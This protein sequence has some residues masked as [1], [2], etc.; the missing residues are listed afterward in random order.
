MVILLMIVGAL[1]GL[2]THEGIGALLGATIGWLVASAIRQGRRIAQ[3]EQ[4]LGERAER[5]V[6]PP[7]DRQTQ[8]GPTP[9][10]DQAREPATAAAAAAPALASPVSSLATA[11]PPSPPLPSAAPSPIVAPIPIPAR[12][13]AAAESDTLAPGERATRPASH[14]AAGPTTPP[15][16]AGEAAGERRSLLGANTII[17]VG[18][19]ILFVGLAFL[20]KYLAGRVTIPVELRL[21][22]IAL[23]AIVLTLIG[24]W[25][26][27]RRPRYAQVLQGGGIAVLYL[28]LF[29]SFRWYGVLAMAPAFVLMAI[30]AMLAAALAVLQEA[31]A[32]AVVGALGG[33]ATPLLVSTGVGNH[34][35]LFTYYLVLDLA[36]AAIAWFRN[37]RPLNLIG[38]AF[39]GGVGSLWGATSYQPAY[40]VSAQFFLIAF[41]LVFIAILILPARSAATDDEGEPISEQWLNGS[42][43]FGLPTITFVLQHGLVHHLRYG[44]AFAALLLAAFYIWLAYC[45][46]ASPRMRVLFESCLAIATVFL[47]LV[48]PLAFDAHT[49]AGAWALEGAG[50]V[51]LGVRLQRWFTRSFGYLLLFGA[52][53]VLIRAAHQAGVPLRWLNTTTLSALMLFAGALLAAFAVRRQA[54]QPTEHP[55]SKFGV[56]MP[57]EP[58]LV[59]GGLL[60]A[61][62]VGMLHIDAL[63]AP[64]LRLAA[65]I[66]GLAGLALLLTLLAAR[67]HW[68]GVAWPLLGL[69]PALL[70]AAGVSALTQDNPFIKN[71]GWAWLLALAAHLAALRYAAAHWS[72]RGAHQAHTIGFLVLAALGALVGRA[73]TRDL[74]DLGSA[75]PWLGWLAA[76]A[77]LLLAL[78]QPAFARRWPASAAPTAYQRSAGAVLAVALFGW[79]LAANVASNGSA[80]PLPYLPLLSPLDLGV[81]IALFA[82][83]RW[84]LCPAAAEALR[85]EP[86]L[87][88]AALGAAA[89]F[90]LN[91]MLVR[92]F[93]HY[94][95]VPLRLSAWIDSLAVQTGFTLLWAATAL[96]LMWFGAQRALRDRWMVGAALL[97]AV[98]LKLLILDLAGSGTLTRVVSFIGAGGLMLVIGYVAPLPAPE[99]KDG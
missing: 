20:A 34:V 4:A 62:G 68:P 61:L 27:T 23:V 71:G 13:A 56:T 40:Y 41:F 39:T 90:W 53:L 14:P 10:G 88:P 69:A 31:P 86:K 82:G 85:A 80:Q 66:S 35:A 91:A 89:F 49:T 30:V 48:I 84:S 72:E 17:Y 63:L 51:W 45:L 97:T 8:V 95:D 21:S 73:L 38:F 12:A 16:D 98:V 54:A 75:W 29:V 37:W 42:L 59:G 36:I 22:A 44:S 79:T 65:A 87:A 92:G 99:K 57:P 3:L 28:T 58:I 55:A 15:T 32:L 52:G 7:A 1:L 26:R 19:A 18:I 70:L 46:R 76:P 33:F 83:W 11:S 5:A 77:A 50:L 25:L 60:V 2:G 94:D 6:T 96:A 64:E 67:L 93:Y 74:G 9:A 43:L 24:W 78:P 81:A 47:T